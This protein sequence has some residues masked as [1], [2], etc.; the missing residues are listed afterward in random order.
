MFLSASLVLLL[1][2]TFLPPGIAGTGT[3]VAAQAVL[4]IGF[5]A[6][7]HVTAVGAF[8]FMSFLFFGMRPL[9]LVIEGDTDLLVGL[10]RTGDSLEIRHVALAWAAAGLW[11]LAA[12]CH[13]QRQLGGWQISSLLKHSAR[14]MLTARYALL[15][16]QAYRAALVIQGVA[17]ALIMVI[18]TG[19]R[20]IYSSG[21]GA[22]V[23]DIPM[24]LQGLQLFGVA[25]AAERWRTQRTTQGRNSLG[26]ALAM[27]TL[28]AWYARDVTLF[29]GA[30]IT[31]LMAAGFC[32]MFRFKGRVSYAWLILPI[33][34]LLPIF[35]TLGQNRNVGN[36]EF[37]SVVMNKIADA[38]SPSSY[39]TFFEAG[40]DINIF[41]TFIAAIQYEPVYKPYI[42]SWIYPPF[43]IIPR[44]IWSGKPD[45]GILQ[46]LS[47]TN[48]APYSPG[49][50]GF[51]WGDGGPLW[52][53][54]SM[55]VLGGL[56]SWV[57]MKVLRLAPGYLKICTYAIVVV[58]ALYLTRF[59]LWQSL[60][61]TFYFLVPCWLIARYVVRQ[62]TG[63]PT[64]SPIMPL[65]RPASGDR[66]RQSN[67]QARRRGR[68]Q[69]GR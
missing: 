21:L 18:S 59:F 62:R 41:D 44:A 29:R 40:G 54:G 56:L 20:G 39:W 1:L 64:G 27:L 67:N 38:L 65:S 13:V 8:L 34:L 26:L 30:Y 24:V 52:M 51:F 19:G 47:Y 22:Y 15:R 23:W 4:L 28:T 16:P 14:P 25:V 46:D 35:R 6:E 45:A 63:P 42:L 53:L 68:G 57:D 33:V 66:L 31:P 11:L 37:G 60:W 48:G 10:F 55:F 61:Q 32:L 17:L 7:R 2:G 43:H 9:Y 49:L 3:L 50:V 69:A 5:I 36:V 12:G 58:N